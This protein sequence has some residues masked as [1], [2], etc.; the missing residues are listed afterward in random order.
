[1]LPVCEELCIGF[2]PY[3]PLGRG[4]LTGAMDETT[5]FGGND[6]RA[7]LPRFTPE[8]LKANRPVVDLL[9]EIADQKGATPAQIALAWLLSHK[10]WI[11][12]IP[13]TTK[14]HR[15]DENIGAASVNLTAND[16]RH[17]E[18]A[19]SNIDVQGDRYPQSERE[20][21]GR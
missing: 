5:I 13:G 1:V 16:L 9:R 3:S 6:N 18:D 21:T 19:V 17:I 20:R 7:T 4:Y 14:L 10:P 11:V 15:L 12:P 2:V 8:A